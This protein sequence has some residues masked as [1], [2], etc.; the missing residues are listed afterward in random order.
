MN[1]AHIH[2]PV[3]GVSCR[4]CEK[5]IR[6]SASF[7][8]TRNNDQASGIGFEPRVVFACLR[9][10]MPSLPGGSH[11]RPQPHCGFFTSFRRTAF[12]GETFGQDREPRKQIGVSEESD[13]WP[14]TNRAGRKLIFRLE[15]SSRTYQR[16]LTDFNFL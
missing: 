1:A 4:F 15:A 2:P 7:I 16:R 14:G 3:R 13:R 6:L 10:E 8:S 9:Y 11:M 5:P 12:V